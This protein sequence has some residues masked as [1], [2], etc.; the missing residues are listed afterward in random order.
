MTAPPL[1]VVMVQR[2]AAARMHEGDPHVVVV[3]AATLRV[4]RRTRKPGMCD[5][6][7]ARRKS[8]IFYWMV[9]RYELLSLDKGPILSFF[10]LFF[11][12][13]FHTLNPG[14]V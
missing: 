4:R 5:L 6:L 13:E 2:D 10:F 8:V 11:C 14:M 9:P 12:G 7:P 3:V 1:V